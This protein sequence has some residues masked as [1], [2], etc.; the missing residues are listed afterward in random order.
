[1]GL[2]TFLTVVRYLVLFFCLAAFGFDMYFVY[3]YA[4]YTQVAITYKFAIETGLVGLLGLILTVSEISLRISNHYRRRSYQRHSGYKVADEYTS[5]SSPPAPPSTIYGGEIS[6][7][8]EHQATPLQP[9]QQ[10]SH[11]CKTFW[12][13]IRLLVV[14]AI[15]GGLLKVAITTYQ[16]Q[17][18]FIF[19]LSFSR[20]STQADALNYDFS[21]YDPRDLFNCPDVSLPNLLT[22]LCLFDQIT[23]LLA[24]LSALL[25]IVEAIA[26]VILDNRVPRFT[27]EEVMMMSV[28]R[29]RSG[30][31]KSREV[32]EDPELGNVHVATVPVPIPEMAEAALQ[33]NGQVNLQRPLP[34]LPVRPTS[35]DGTEKGEQ[36]M[37]QAPKF[38]KPGYSPFEN[39][40]KDSKGACPT[41][42]ETQNQAGPSNSYPAD[43]KRHDGS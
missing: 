19:T 27:E 13:I 11:G 20:D 15:S 41:P 8:D 9:M 30:M 16:H 35:G 38:T 26:T 6:S 22:T 34:P 39:D 3:M 43:I 2:A 1:M 4:R 37:Y 33:P 5:M 10:G 40:F 7:S 36:Y 21:S 24:G 14:W 29:R 31:R 42:N 12:S 18:R 28:A 25:A 32:Y 17:E 23:V